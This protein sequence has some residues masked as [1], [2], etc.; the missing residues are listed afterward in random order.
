MSTLQGKNGVLN[1]E[2]SVSLATGVQNTWFES[3]TSDERI[4]SRH[5][6]STMYEENA[7][8]VTTSGVGV[9]LTTATCRI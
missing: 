6:T 7:L 1:F 9:K 5:S 2:K 8:V 4:S 3:S